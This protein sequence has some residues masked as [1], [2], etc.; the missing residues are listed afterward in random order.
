MKVR[1][2]IALA[3]VAGATAS[4]G[5]YEIRVRFV[6]QVGLGA[7]AFVVLPGNTID[8]SDGLARRIRV[9]FGVFDDANGAAPLG[10]YVGWNVG[11]LTVSGPSGN[12][13][14]TRTPGRVNPFTFAPGGNGVP[15]A[16]PFDAITGV[17]NTL[18]TQ[19][20]AWPVGA[21]APNPALVRGR[22]VFV[23][24]YEFTVN[25]I[26]VGGS[27]YSVTLGGNVI[28]ATEWRFVG[29]PTPPSDSDE[30]GVD[31][32]AGSATYAPFPTAPS[33]ISGVLN[34]IVPGPGSV[35]LLGLGGLL[36]ARRRRA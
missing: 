3:L 25:P 1:S 22:N 20:T 15:A 30:D 33:A 34:V 28:A 29:T 12:S 8:C 14:E 9:Q 21:G 23:S 11:S 2:L 18:G 5:A 31:D 32:T 17:D 36:A 27:N 13:A 10:G 7:G 26:D 16:D 24:T 4:A 6:E 35:A 19:S